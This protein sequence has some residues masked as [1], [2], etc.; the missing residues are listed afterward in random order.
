[1]LMVQTRSQTQIKASGDVKG[2]L[3]SNQDTIDAWTD[4]DQEGLCLVQLSIAPSLL[5]RMQ[6]CTTLFQ[7]WKKLQQAYQPNNRASRV[8]CIKQLAALQLSESGNVQ[9][10]VASLSELLDRLGGLNLSFHDDVR[11]S[12]LLASLPE[13]WNTF[14]IALEA[15]EN[16]LGFEGASDLILEESDCRSNHQATAHAAQTALAAQAPAQAAQAAPKPF[17]SRGNWARDQAAKGTAPSR[18]CSHCGAMHWNF[19]CTQKASTPAA[20]APSTAPSAAHVASTLPLLSELHLGTQ[21]HAWMAAPAFQGFN[22]WYFDSGASHH[23]TAHSQLFTERQAIRPEPIS[24]ANGESIS[25]V[26]AGTARIAV[27]GDSGVACVDLNG[28]LLAPELK[29][30]LISVSRLLRQGLVVTFRDDAVVV[31]DKQQH[32]LARGV[33]E[34]GL[35]RLVQP[36]VADY[37]SGA[38]IYAF[39]ALSA[40]SLSTWHQRF[41][42]L[43]QQAIRW[44]ASSRLVGG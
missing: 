42:H 2:A 23:M 40:P 43:S 26:A 9:E 6:G 36:P 41:G 20:S 10:H 8:H 32:V 1:M 17:R 22:A 38:P 29:T 33:K 11:S 12:L 37:S 31:L 34:H 15:R 25:A 28:A 16:A 4:L 7:A 18:P 14:V 19:Q 21:G 44:L 13:S 24:I 3:P 39:A 5:W 35:F 30:N 27:I